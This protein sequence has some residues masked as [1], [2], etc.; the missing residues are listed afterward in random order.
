MKPVIYF[1]EAYLERCKSLTTEQCLI[2]LN[3]YQRMQ[4]K[5]NTRITISKIPQPRWLHLTNT[6]KRNKPTS[7]QPFPVISSPK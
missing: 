7:L 3:A 1:D 4:A 2:F 6:P 5:T